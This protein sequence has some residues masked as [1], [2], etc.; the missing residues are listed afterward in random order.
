MGSKKKD[1]VSVLVGGGVSAL[2]SPFLKVDS[3]SR[4]GGPEQTEYKAMPRPRPRKSIT[5][6]EN[7]FMA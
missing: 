4:R 6:K 1:K 7:K 2:P 5:P 3:D